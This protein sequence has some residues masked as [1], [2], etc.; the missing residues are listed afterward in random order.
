MAINDVEPSPRY[1]DPGATIVVIPL[2]TSSFIDAVAKLEASAD[3]AMTYVSEDLMTMP[4]SS[5]KRIPTGTSTVMQSYQEEIRLSNSG[6]VLALTRWAHLWSLDKEEGS[7]LPDRL[8]HSMVRW[9]GQLAAS[10][11]G[12]SRRLAPRYQDD[13]PM[14]SIIGE[15]CVDDDRS[16]GTPVL[17]RLR[18]STSDTGVV[19]KMASMAKLLPNPLIKLLQDASTLEAIM[20]RIDNLDVPLDST[21]AP[22]TGLVEQWVDG[23]F[24]ALGQAFNVTADEIGELD[25]LLWQMAWVTIMENAMTMEGA[26]ELAVG[27]FDL[28]VAS[29]SAAVKT[30]LG[31]STN[32]SSIAITAYMDA[33]EALGSHSWKFTLGS[34]IMK[35]AE[36]DWTVKYKTTPLVELRDLLATINKLPTWDWLREL[37]SET[38]GWSA[39]PY[40]ASDCK[41]LEPLDSGRL[42]LKAYILPDYAWASNSYRMDLDQAFETSLLNDIEGINVDALPNDI[43]AV[44]FPE[45]STYKMSTGYL[46]DGW[47][48]GALT[49]GAALLRAKSA[50]KPITPDELSLFHGPIAANLFSS[51][52]PAWRTLLLR[53]VVRPQDCYRRKPVLTNIGGLIEQT[54]S[55]MVPV[56]AITMRVDR[57]PNPTMLVP[58]IGNRMEQTKF[59]HIETLHDLV[60]YVDARVS[61]VTIGDLI[62]TTIS[63]DYSNADID[64]ARANPGDPAFISLVAGAAGA[65]L[66]DPP[67]PEVDNIL[68]NTSATA[69]LAAYPSYV[70][71]RRNGGK[72]KPLDPTFAW[73]DSWV[74]VIVSAGGTINLAG[75]RSVRSESR[76]LSAPE[77][78]RVFHW[79][80]RAMGKS[81]VVI[82]TVGEATGTVSHVRWSLNGPHNQLSS[83]QNGM[84][85]GAM[86]AA[87][88]DLEVDWLR[89]LTLLSSQLRVLTT[90]FPSASYMTDSESQDVSYPV[91]A[92]VWKRSQ[93]SYAIW[94][95]YAMTAGRTTTGRVDPI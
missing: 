2:P 94:R 21:G 45:N 50:P 5:T 22:V 55:L 16:P 49:D 17:D 61:G 73:L 18:A 80:E 40:V 12:Q 88:V 66:N 68:S 36:V 8:S 6:W 35:S 81:S 51:E 63:T 25:T 79:G 3:T 89:N 43:Q 31:V 47:P 64:V 71:W 7:R 13:G 4:V 32:I 52:V 76:D 78:R 92:S 82:T 37:S 54:I 46:H 9:T 15:F 27:G 19:A 85:V 56:D 95:D 53:P 74:L 65:T 38:A 77:L 58:V 28:N 69:I 87:V 29:G 26:A 62:R 23:N 14:A 59:A 41:E 33:W 75:E 84:E 91:T 20:R 39:H 34:D 60:K 48:S 93:S 83:N 30:A 44:I 1:V 90:H 57:S 10:L 67:I 86:A 24:A 42:P 70:K 72:G 11:L